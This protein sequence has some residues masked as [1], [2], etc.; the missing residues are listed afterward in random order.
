MAESSLH[1]SSSP[2]IKE[3]VTLDKPKSPNPF[4][5]T[6]QVDFTFDEIAFTT[7]NEVALI[8]PSHPNQEYFI[9]VSNFISKCCLKEAFT[10]AST[11][12]KEYLSEFW[13][14]AKTLDNS[15]VWVSTP[16]CRV[17]GEIGYTR[18]IGSKGTLK[19]SCLPPRWRLLMAQIMDYN[20]IIWDDLIHKLNK[21][22]REKIFPYPR[23]ISLL[24]EHMA[25][26]YENKE[27]T[28]NPTQVFS[29]HNL[30][31]KPNQPEEP[32]FTDHMKA[33]CNLVV[34]VDSKAPKLSSQ[35][36]KVP[37]GK[38]PEATTGL[39]RKRSLKHTS[40]SKT[41]AS[42]SQTTQSKI[43]T[44]S[45]ST[46]DKIPSHP[47][48]STLVV[49]E[50]HK[51]AQQAAGSLTSLGAISEEGAHPQLSSDFTAEADPG[52]SA[53]NDSIL[54]QQ[55]DLMKDT[56]SAF[57]TPDFPPD[58]PI[59]VLE[60]GGQEEVK[61]AKETPTTSQDVLE[62]TSA[63]AEAEV[64]SLNVKP[65]Y[66]DI[67]QFITLL[68]NSLKPKLSK[69]LAS[70]DFA[71]CL[72]T[73]LKELPSKIIGLS[74]ENKELKQHIKYMEIELLRDLKVIPSKVETFTFTISNLSSQEKLKTLDSLP[75]LLKTV[76]NTLNR[77]ATMVESASGATTT[78]VPSADKATASPAEG[79]KDADTN[80]KNKLVDLLGIDIVTQYYNK[81]LLYER[82]CEKMK[83]RRQSSKIIS[84]DVLT[85]KGPVSLKR[86]VVQACPDIKEKGWKTIYEL[87]KT[88]MEYLEQTEKELHIDFNKSLQEQN[89]MDELNELANKKRKRTDRHGGFPSGAKK[90][91]GLSPKAKVRVLHTAQLDV[92]K[93]YKAGKKLLYG[94]RNKAIS[95]EK[96]S[97]KVSREGVVGSGENGGKWENKGLLRKARNT[98]VVI[99]NPSIRKSVGIRLL[100]SG[101]FRF[102][103]GVS[104][105]NND[106]TILKILFDPWHVEVF[107]L[108][109][110]VWNLIPSSNP[111]RESIKLY[112]S[113]PVVI[114]R[115]MYCVPFDKILANG[116]PATYMIISF[117]LITK[118]FKEVTVTVSLENQ[119]GSGFRISKLRDSLI[120]FG[121]SNEVNESICVQIMVHDGVITSFT[122]LFTID[123]R[124]LSVNKILGFRK[125]GEVVMENAMQIRKFAA[126]EVYEPC[127]QDTEDLEIYGDADSFFMGS[128]KET[129]LLLDHS[130]GYI[131]SHN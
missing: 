116:W 34:H 92:T 121:E 40:E 48:P 62:D 123:N 114:D 39:R 106:P 2:E 35:T 29:V 49:G 26:E 88:R 68:V 103:F 11:Q 46:K 69:L 72:P 18:E 47:S 85:K 50:M 33:I 4:L 51:E 14:I 41:K 110:A 129:L 82:Y 20:K 96:G 76:T 98:R 117:D 16:T 55:A 63:A 36:E 91:W 90:K 84:C 53:S 31:L 108:S 111:P 120:L 105:V 9:V 22:T 104:P 125:S 95:F 102:G 64:A 70:H 60:E 27:L 24:L 87:I 109:S 130:D 67:N 23:F 131:Y 74:R 13:Y 112:S 17:R 21:K 65:S 99:W 32:P 12:Y 3:P 77:F 113:T 122:K 126:L 6:T 124:N 8:Y 1:K 44:Q 61:K 118:K 78:S 79:E 28:I 10:R 73:D 57:F 81:K 59:N 66:P 19:K 97:S 54:P 45:N 43:E 127:S 119:F 80:L 37:Q 128:Y 107:T 30:T 5:H 52:P 25:P 89:P 15:K 93:V 42:K 56:R 101:Y 38:K 75:G 71:S 94:K 100:S 86:E 7:N 83:K 115:F 58:E